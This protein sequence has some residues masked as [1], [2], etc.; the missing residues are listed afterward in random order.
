MTEA[1]QIPVFPLPVFLLPGGMT[2]L[3][4]FEPRYLK[5]VRLASQGQGFVI[6]TTT[7]SGALSELG[8]WVMIS[9]FGQSPNGLLQIDVQ[10][11]GLVRLTDATRDADQLLWARAQL[12]DH[13]ATEAQSAESQAFADALGQCLRDNELLS[14]LYPEPLL[15]QANWVVARWLELAPIAN[16]YKVLFYPADSYANAV[17]LLA[18]IL[19]TKSSAQ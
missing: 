12:T 15:D 4:I 8:A 6:Q 10:C 1:M 16:H 7:S 17:T 2:R 13:W 3:N 14:T 19:L 11:R 5:M 9:N 18:E